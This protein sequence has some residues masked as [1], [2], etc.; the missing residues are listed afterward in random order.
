MKKVFLVVSGLTAFMGGVVL[1]L[2]TL[3]IIVDPTR[4]SL[5]THIPSAWVFMIWGITV[6]MLFIYGYLECRIKAEW[7]REEIRHLLQIRGDLK[8]I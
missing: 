7:D 4:I 3:S 5:I 1:A 6:V 8:D 2:W